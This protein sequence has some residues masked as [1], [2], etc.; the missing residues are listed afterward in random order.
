MQLLQLGVGLICVDSVAALTTMAEIE[1]DMGH[2]GVGEQARLMSRSL[3][4]LAAAVK[5][6]KATMIWTNQ[7]RD[8]IGVTWGDKTTTPGGRALK[9]WASIRV[10]IKR[11]ATIKEGTKDD[12]VVVCTRVRAEVKKNKTAP[13]FRKAEFFITFG[14]G[15]DKIAAIVDTALAKKVIVKRG[16]WFSFEDQQIACGR[17]AV[18]E[19]LRTDVELSKKIE[20]AT[21]TAAAV[22]EAAPASEKGPDGVERTPVTDADVQLGTANA[23]DEKSETVVEDAQ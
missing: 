5:R 21:A 8:K 10:E 18:M 17:P 20:A 13:P 4:K 11:I 2:Q 7:I 16:S 3:R 15:I 9:H 19:A 1:G 14:H 23:D 6:H 22:K 12:A